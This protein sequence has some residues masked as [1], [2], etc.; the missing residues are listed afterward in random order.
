MTLF[1]QA[2]L[3][4]DCSLSGLSRLFKKAALPIKHRGYKQGLV[5]NLTKYIVVNVHFMFQ[6][7]C[8]PF[9]FNLGMS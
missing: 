9:F 4:L 3:R 1:I 5:M 6:F 2:S 7:L 8:S